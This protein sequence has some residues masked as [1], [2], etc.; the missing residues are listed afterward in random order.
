M[1]NFP[2]SDH[3]HESDHAHHGAHAHHE[4]GAADPVR[5]MTVSPDT[6]PR[7][8]RDGPVLLFCSARCKDRFV[9]DATRYLDGT[10]PRDREEPAPSI[11]ATEYTCPMHPE[12]VRDGPGSCPICGMA[13]EPKMP[14]LDQGPDPELV[15][16]TRRF[17]I[18]AALTLPLLV[19]SKGEMVGL[20]I[21]SGRARVYTELLLALP[22]CTWGAWPFYR[23]FAASLANRSLNMFPLLRAGVRAG[24]DLSGRAPL[25]HGTL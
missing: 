7:V 20:S 22:V 13:L 16:M 1:P 11:G 9:A 18:S 3:A 12:I 21:L 10:R 23:R 15:D 4:H 14:A 24:V 25:G 6:P 5:G 2:G 19:I 17:W 8:M